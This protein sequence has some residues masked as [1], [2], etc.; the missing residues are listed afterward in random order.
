MDAPLPAIPV[1]SSG[2]P[3]LPTCSPESKAPPKPKGKIRTFLDRHERILWWGHS[4]YALLFGVGFMWLGSANFTYLRIAIFHLGFIWASS[5]LLPIVL[6]HPKVTGKWRE[7]VRLV[8]NYFN[9]NFSQQILFFLLPLYHQSATYSSGHVLFMAVLAT[10]AVLS[11]LDVVYDRHLSVR[12]APMSLFVAFNL[13]ACLN[14]MLPV[15]WTIGNTHALIISATLAVTAFS[16]LCYRLSGL[17]GKRRTLATISAALLL[18]V[19]AFFGRSLVPP[20]PL[21]IASASFGLRL[22][23]SVLACSPAL[24]R[25]PAGRP[26]HPLLLTAIR[27]PLGL[28]EKVGHVWHLNG[29]VLYR[30]GFYTVS[31]GRKEGFRLWTKASLPP[32]SAGDR[33]WVEVCTEGGQL[34]G[35]A[36][37]PVSEV[38]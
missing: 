12:W 37:I 34:V 33:I 20:A 27:A 21:R 35:T 16:T 18:L 11:T 17:Q 23:R 6:D 1:Q 4:I 15:L 29:R 9:K 8:V 38:P 31:G 5:L 28:K 25:L 36:D 19:L 2:E 3:D 24:D 30:S 26:I 22:D 10:S 13:F 32:L 7:R 14:V